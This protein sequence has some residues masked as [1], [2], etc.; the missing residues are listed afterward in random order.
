MQRF[1]FILLAG[2]IF[3]LF[4]S[5]IHKP[6]ELSEF[7]S[8]PASGPVKDQWYDFSLL[9]KELNNDTTLW[10]LYLEIRYTKKFGFEEFPLLLEH[11]DSKGDTVRT[12]TVNVPLMTNQGDPLGKGAYGIYQKEVLLQKEIHVDS[13]FFISLSTPL[14][15][16][17]GIKDIG[18]ILKQNK[19]I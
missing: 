6:E 14:E 5:C 15:N 2:I 13:T 1:S 10:N 11:T 4:F 18:I 12:N 3:S 16:S 17:S 19:N 7:I 9:N 8:F